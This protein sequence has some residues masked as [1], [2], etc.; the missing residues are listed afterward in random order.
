MRRILWV[1]AIAL[2]MAA[3]SVV[4]AGPAMARDPFPIPT[5]I[6]GEITSHISH[7]RDLP[8]SHGHSTARFTVVERVGDSRHAGSNLGRLGR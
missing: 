7:H 1:L 4:M 3:I 2:V 6:Y 8:R 5:P